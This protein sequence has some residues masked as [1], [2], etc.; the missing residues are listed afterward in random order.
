MSETLIDVMPFEYTL[1]EASSTGNLRV[2]GVFQRADVLNENKR[3]YPRVIWENTLNNSRVID[4]LSSR[5]MFG[6]LDHPADGKTKLS[7][8][9]HIITNLKLEDTGEVIGEAEILPT[10]NGKI[11]KQLF[12]SG[13]R[14]GI[15]SRGSGSVRDRSDG[16]KE[17]CEDFKLSTFDFVARP[18]T[19]GA[20]PTTVTTR[21]RVK[22]EAEFTTANAPTTHEGT[23]RLE[24]DKDI[25]RE[26]TELG[27]DVFSI[28]EEI[29]KF[30]QNM[31]VEDKQY[32]TAVLDELNR[33]IIQLHSEASEYDGV[34]TELLEKV[35]VGQHMLK[36]EA[37]SP[38][39]DYQEEQMNRTD[40]I[41]ERLERVL[42]ESSEPEK[43]K[44]M[45][46]DELRDHL[47]S[48]SDE[49]LLAVADEVGLE[50]EE[51]GEEEEVDLEEVAAYIEALEEEVDRLQKLSSALA[52]NL[53]E[54]EDDG[55]AVKYEAALGVIAELASEYD[56]LVEA[57]GGEEE[58]AK[59]VEAAAEQDD[60]AEDN[61]TGSGDDGAETIDENVVA[62]DADEL[63]EEAAAHTSTSESKESQRM[64][65]LAASAVKRLGFK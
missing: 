39:E 34:L 47:S 30:N 15:S 13:T 9:A 20:I 40:I 25:F 52:E 41:K 65:E 11:L 5:G 6:E 19:P 53:E 17:V 22:E 57:V 4:D 63:A 58:A 44:V 32:Y 45:T 43:E 62:A 24:A 31:S 37:A 21:K 18:S 2:R 12:E 50:L 51:A 26:V 8:A 28:L 54:A 16:A 61:K 10:P 1:E 56:Q 48:L 46:E 55:L 64:A 29:D 7:R 38:D 60:D 33:Q 3:L 27:G 35:S 36:N 14:V 49:E 59:L 42:N 23:Q